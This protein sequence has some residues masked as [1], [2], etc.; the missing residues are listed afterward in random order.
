MADNY[1][2]FPG[3]SPS[4]KKTETELASAVDTLIYPSRHMST[5]VANFNPKNSMFLPNGVDYDWFSKRG[6]EIP[7][8]YYKI[9]E[10]RLLYVG[11]IE[12]WFDFDLVTEAA[13]THT[14]V[15]FVL[16]G[17]KKLALKRLPK[18]PN[19]YLLGSRKRDGLAGYYEHAQGAMIPFNV[20]RY[21][22]LLHPVRPL[23][24]FEYLS[25]GL[26]T[27]SMSWEELEVLDAPIRLVNDKQCFVR[28]IS[29]SFFDGH[30]GADLREFAYKYDW[31]AIFSDFLS[32]LE[33]L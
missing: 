23:K 21:P 4:F 8:E 14:N 2:G 30:G 25:A 27:L 10:P 28:S 24:L 26:P 3:Y 32:H 13:T 9:P 19:L 1:S 11:A 7:K 5:L 22:V 6:N 15:S 17:S 33:K 31:E 20:E 29:K 18:L 12:E 16:I